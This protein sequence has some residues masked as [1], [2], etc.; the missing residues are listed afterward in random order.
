[1]L[2]IQRDLEASLAELARPAN[3]APANQ[4]ANSSHHSRWL[5]QHPPR[6]HH[7]K[8][9]HQHSQHQEG[10]FQNGSVTQR[11]ALNHLERDGWTAKGQQPLID[12]VQQM[13]RFVIVRRTGLGALPNEMRRPIIVIGDH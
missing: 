13:S 12:V 7:H 8:H 10:K 1:M 2:R 6:H 4:R 11:A 5:L 9:Q 3:Q